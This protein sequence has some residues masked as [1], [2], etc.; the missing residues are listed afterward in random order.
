MIFSRAP[1]LIEVFAK[2]VAGKWVRRSVPT[3]GAPLQ[4]L[5]AF[6]QWPRASSHQFKLPHERND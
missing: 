4:P 6:G 2:K 3:S 5:A 1:R